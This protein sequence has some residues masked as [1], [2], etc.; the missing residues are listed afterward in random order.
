MVGLGVHRLGLSRLQRSLDGGSEGLRRQKKQRRM[1]WS[2]TLLVLPLRS[3]APGS[4]FPA[5]SR[6]VGRNLSRRR[7][8]WAVPKPEGLAQG[9]GAPEAQVSPGRGVSPRGVGQ[10]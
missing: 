3:P 7:Q 4:Q 8:V 1:L 10:V 5:L 6:L 2:L 9:A